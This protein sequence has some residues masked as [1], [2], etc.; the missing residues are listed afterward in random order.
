MFSFL[1][2]VAVTA[3]NT[4]E[5]S[6]VESI[7]KNFGLNWSLFISSVI[8]FFLVV[9]V[10]KI[11]AFKPIGEMLEQRR[12]RIEEGEEKL[13]RIEKQL[14]QSEERTQ[15]AIEDAHMESRKLI[16]Q[17]K[18]SAAELSEQK[19][20]EAI[21]AAQHILKKAELSAQSE[22]QKIAAE[23]KKEFTS[24][25]AASTARVTQKVLTEKDQQ[26]LAQE[27]ITTLE[28]SSSS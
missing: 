12:K 25:L 13:K 20:Q 8:S 11:F 5:P 16:E 10:L 3:H 6:V 24:L 14:A 22:R 7:S 21:A 26:I 19:T 2:I 1:Q 18:L 4:A 27:S 23:L 9:L 17:A 15:K 28:Q